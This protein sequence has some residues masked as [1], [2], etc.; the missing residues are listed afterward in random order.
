MGHKAG[1]WATGRRAPLLV[2]VAGLLHAASQQPPGCLHSQQQ[3]LSKDGIC[4]LHRHAMLVQ[5]RLQLLQQCKHNSL[6]TVHR[7]AV[8]AVVETFLLLQS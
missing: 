2:R 1:I 3:Q 6:R 8:A 5:L 7:A 4:I